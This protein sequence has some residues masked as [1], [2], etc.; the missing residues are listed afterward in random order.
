[1]VISSYNGY[2]FNMTI[3]VLSDPNKNF[4][5][6]VLRSKYNNFLQSYQ[7]GQFK[8]DFGFKP[9]YISISDKKQNYACLL[10]SKKIPFLG[11]IYYIPA[12][13]IGEDG[14]DFDSFTK[15]LKK[16]LYSYDPKAFLLKI[17]PSILDTDKNKVILKKAGYIKSRVNPQ[18]SSTIVL[19]IEHGFDHWLQELK[20][21]TRYNI[22]LA[23]RKGVEIHLVEPSKENIDVAYDLMKSMQIKKGTFLRPK[24]YFSSLYQYF[25]QA[26][27]GSLLIAYYQEIPLAMEF[28]CHFG[29]YSYYKDGASQD[30]FRNLMPSYLI[31]AEAVKLSSA[32][33][34]KYYDMSGS[35]PRNDINNSSHGFYGITKFKTNFSTDIIEYIGCYDFALNPKKKMLWDRAERYYLKLYQRFKKDLFW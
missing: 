16:F 6:I 7:W 30:K 23:K 9:L 31:Q 35:V 28:V 19:N 32:K 17:Q 14:F 2:N 11:T 15:G 10:L 26:G 8:K 20:Q 1:M 29:N 33:G 25:I 5:K 24:R 27:F 18:V 22:N 21:K 34:C 12:G 4:N 3:S 13:P